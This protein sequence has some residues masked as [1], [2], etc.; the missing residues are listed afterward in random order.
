MASGFGV[1]LGF[2]VE[3]SETDV[4]RREVVV[5]FQSLFQVVFGLLVFTTRLQGQRQLNVRF[6]SSRIL[7][8]NNPVMPD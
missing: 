6:G 5:E 3:P 1:T 2:Q 7:C 8:Q 4:D